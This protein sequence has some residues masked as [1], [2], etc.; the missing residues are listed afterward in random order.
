MKK[1][2]LLLVLLLSGMFSFGQSNTAVDSN[3]VKG[4]FFAGLRE[5]LNENYAR[6][7]ENFNKI[8]SIDPDNAAV[9]YEIA[10]LSYRQNKLTEAE[11]SIRKALGI[12]KENIWYWKM[13]AE[14]YKRKGDMPGLVK[15]FD[16]M[17]RLSPEND[18]YYFDKCNAQLLMGDTASAMKGYELI[19]QK[20]GPSAELDEARQRVASG[21]GAETSIQQIDQIISG[22]VSDLKGALNKSELLMEKGD[23]AAALLLLKKTE[24]AY[25]E[26]YEVELALADHYKALKNSDEAAV[27]LRKAFSNAQMPVEQKVKIMMMVAADQRNP[28]HLSDAMAMGQVLLDTH[29]EDPKVR[30]W[31]GDL[32]LQSGKTEAALK[33]YQ[34]ALKLAEDQYGVWQKLLNVQTNAGKYQEAIQTGDAALAIFPNQAILYYYYAFALHREDRNAEAKANIKQ[35]L[36]LD[37]ENPE[38]QA[39]VLALQGEIAIDEQQFQKANQSFDQAL[40][41]APTNYMIIN[42]YAYYLALRNQQLS[43]ASALIA[44]AAAALPNNASIADTYALVLFRQQ[45]YAEARIWIEKAL[46]NNTEENSVYLEHYGDILFLGGEEEQ[47]LQQWKKSQ[48]AGNDDE[49]LSRKINENKY[50]K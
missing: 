27:A 1:E 38:M 2:L 49:K 34:E 16:E 8:L 4:L 43:K 19:L 5:K 9:H 35:A 29:P 26:S 44:R 47:G 25:P 31:Y 7:A 32:L 45:K 6:A 40:Q 39:L 10:V 3:A 18:A 15:V 17:I 12:D 11:F 23:H 37:G 41:L 33:Q 48:L 22:T 30:E 14:L 50:I 36:S 21:N 28:A 46:Q 20:F 42:N 24:E 13:L